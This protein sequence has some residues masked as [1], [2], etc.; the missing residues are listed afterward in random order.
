MVPI[1]YD[2]LNIDAPYTCII[3]VQKSVN[4]TIAPYTVREVKE[5]ASIRHT[6]C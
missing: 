4:F 6:G 2:I 1:H 5:K 3:A